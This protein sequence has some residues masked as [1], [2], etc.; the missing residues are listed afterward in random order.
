MNILAFDCAVQGMGI[1]VLRDGVCLAS[2][3]EGGR[4]QT[5][6]LL[7]AIETV[8]VEAGLDRRDLSLIVVTL[9]PGSFTGVRVGLA[10]AHGLSAGLGVPL[11]GLRTTAVLLAQAAGDGRVPIAAVD[12]R[13]G[14]WFCEI[15]GD[16]APFVAA[17]TDLVG[18]LRGRQWRVIGSGTKALTT[19]LA[20]AGIDAVAEEAVPD[21]V[22]LGGLAAKTGADVWRRQN[23]QQGLPRP[24]YLRGVNI[25]LP[26]GARRT[27]G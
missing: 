18:R 5:V 14:D 12:S 24:L 19:F 4:D 27:V 1:A 21:P 13:L 3:H 26:D 6:R 17:A 25:T 22:V 9:G 16:D 15:G 23:A 7:P 8:L 2:H 20:A 11:A 10:A